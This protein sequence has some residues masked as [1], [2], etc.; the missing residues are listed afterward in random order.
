MTMLGWHRIGGYAGLEPAR[1]LDYG[2]L[3]ALRVAG[4][5][6]VKNGPTTAM[7]EG[8]VPHD[9]E[10]FEVPRPL[11]GVRL[12][13][14]VRQSDDPSR[15]IERVS[16]ESTALVQRQLDLPAGE[17]GTVTIVSDRPG[18]LQV[19]TACSVER[20]LFVA[21]SYHSGWQSRIDGVGGS[22]FR[23]N[24]D[25]IGCLVPAGEHDVV[26]E[27]RPQSRRRGFWLSC[28]G[29]TLVSAFFTGR[30][31]WPGSLPNKRS[32]SIA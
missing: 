6:W 4:V 10:W 21:Q 13:T 19:T 30:M 3:A 31:F 24:G 5:R 12:L 26:L 14:K 17:S 22:V 32:E 27:F 9:E 25:F 16:I 1:T 28:L 15:D 18:R 11:T 20:L 23:A 2:R 29:L 7:I 8:V